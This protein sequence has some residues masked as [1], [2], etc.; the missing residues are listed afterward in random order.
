MDRLADVL[1][2]FTF[3]MFFYQQVSWAIRD[4]A[5]EAGKKK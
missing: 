5:R 1:I 2:G 3:G 4:Y